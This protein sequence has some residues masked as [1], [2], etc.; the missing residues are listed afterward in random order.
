MTSSFNGFSEETVAFFLDLKENNDQGWYNENRD[1]YEMSVMDPSRAFVIAMGKRLPE[2]SP[3]LV[4]DPR[5]NKSMFRLNRDERFS[6]DK[7]PYK[8]NLGILFWEGP[9]KR[10]ERPSFYFQVEEDRM[11]LAGGMYMIPEGMLERYREVVSKEGPAKVLDGLIKKLKKEGIE[12]GGE[13]YKRMPKGYTEDHPYSYLL[14]HNGVY[15]FV[16][17]GIPKEFFS[18]DLV[19]HCIGIYAKMDPLNR[20]FIEFVC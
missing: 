4:A 5:V 17:T 18:A 16:E 11:M 14:K 1:R 7:T 13:H 20:W 10:M 6:S 3:T 19:D 9:G 8:T 15:A 2:I 12:V